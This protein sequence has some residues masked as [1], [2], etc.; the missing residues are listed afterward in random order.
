[1]GLTVEVHP[2]DRGV[3]AG[4]DVIA[5]RFTQSHTS[6]YTIY[7]EIAKAG[8]ANKVSFIV[9]AC[10]IQCIVTCTVYRY[11]YGY[12]C[13]VIMQLQTSVQLHTAMYYIVMCK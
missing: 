2:S 13:L 6:I 8:W 10:T 5:C 11:N 7:N 9:C 1:M 3:I 12:G 4:T